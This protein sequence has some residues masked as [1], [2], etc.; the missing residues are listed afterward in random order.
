MLM[1]MMDR[2]NTFKVLVSALTI[3]TMMMV[4]VMINQFH[5]IVSGRKDPRAS[6]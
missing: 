3:T 2:S 4:S 1:T 5:V 6:P